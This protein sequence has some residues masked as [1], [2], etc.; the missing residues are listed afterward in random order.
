MKKKERIRKR[1]E[2]YKA[3]RARIVTL[4][5]I[6]WLIC[7]VLITWAAAA[8]M[9]HQ[10]EYSA[11][12]D[13]SYGTNL[14][15]V[16]GTAEYNII[17]S[18]SS[19][20][21]RGNI[22]PTLPIM[23]KQHPSSMSSDE[24]LWG[25]WEL[26]YGFEP[27]RIYFTDD[28]ILFG[29]SDYLLFAYMDLETYQAGNHNA[30]TGYGYIDL[31]SIPSDQSDFH[32]YIN[33]WSKADGMS[34]HVGF[35]DF[36][37]T[38]WFEDGQFHPVTIDVE[39]EGYIGE[40]LLH[41]WK[42][43]LNLPNDS[44]KETTQIYVCIG[45]VI[46][47][48]QKPVTVNGTTFD[49]LTDLLYAD[50]TTKE[51]YRSSN[52]FNAL[53]ITSAHHND[54][55]GEYTVAVAFR[56]C[57]IGY[58]ALRLIPF[59]AVSLAVLLIVLKLILGGIRKNLAEPLD[60]IISALAFHAPLTPQAKWEEVYSLERQYVKIQQALAESNTELQQIRTKLDY[61]QNAEEN[62]RQ[63][64]S[65][66]THELKTPL[67]VIHSYAEGLQEGIAK[68][69]EDQYLSVILEQSEKMDGLVLQMLDFSRL[70]AGKVRLSTDNFS[71]LKL[72]QTVTDRFQPLLEDKDLT[73]QYG[74]CQ[75]FLI[76]ADEARIEQVITNLVS[77]ALKYTEPGNAITVSVFQHDGKAGFSIENPGTWLT[78]E[79]LEKVWDS[80]FRAD[81]SRSTPG[82]GLGLAVVK[83]IIQLHQGSCKAR[84]L[85]YKKQEDT[86]TGVQ[87]SFQIPMG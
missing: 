67:A 68:E 86:Y 65:S 53:I 42:R 38:G 69:K 2:T 12:Q 75:D 18:L 44:G 9:Y 24:W 19:I 49:S 14:G 10:L 35:Q 28:G 48:I 66:L 25:K 29:D 1:P 81:P 46:K 85:L 45:S 55:Y 5:L 41:S 16:P 52:L 7:M 43:L 72:A 71:L 56:C 60:G 33:N 31:N 77:N 36:R 64:V 51:S 11:W 74:V 15:K 78:E 20:Y 23:L 40:S 63:L 13:V 54:A 62:R 32:T 30:R 3:I 8:D 22:D 59:Y 26:V 82:T 80:F 50:R 4:T 57:P 39:Q 37:M 70:E 83:Q 58:A 34:H 47:R 87:F 76:T 21:Y 73:L 84:N 6:L 61:A 17:S 79:Q 27:A